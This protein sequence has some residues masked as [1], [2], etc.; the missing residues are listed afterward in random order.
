LLDIEEELAPI[1]RPCLEQ[2]EVDVDSTMM[3]SPHDPTYNPEDSISDT[4][5]M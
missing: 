4:E 1:K 2:T 5:H 3:Q